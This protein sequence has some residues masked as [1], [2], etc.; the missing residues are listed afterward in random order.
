MARLRWQGKFDIASV[1]VRAPSV[2]FAVA[3]LVLRMND[4][5]RWLALAGEPLCVCCAAAAVCVVGVVLVVMS[6]GCLHH[7]TRIYT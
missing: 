4:S 5:R 3:K 6:E 1:W 2:A 7:I